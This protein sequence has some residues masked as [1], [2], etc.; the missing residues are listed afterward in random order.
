MYGG[1]FVVC[2]KHFQSTDDGELFPEEDLYGRPLAVFVTED[3]ALRNATE[4]D[5]MIVR[6]EDW[7]ANISRWQIFEATEVERWVSEWGVLDERFHWYDVEELPD[8]RLGDRGPLSPRVMEYLQNHFDDDSRPKVDE[9]RLADVPMFVEE[10]LQRTGSFHEV[11]YV[12][13]GDAASEFRKMMI[14]KDE[15]ERYRL[16]F[17]QNAKETLEASLFETEKGG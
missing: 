15:L 6:K 1:L 17:F 11:F 8:A 13:E 4:R 12:T 2:L 9:T 16:R 7:W 5:R 14:D 10:V 3:A